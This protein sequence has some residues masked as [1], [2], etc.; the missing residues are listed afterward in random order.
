MADRLGSAK[1]LLK[2]INYIEQSHK[3][4][5]YSVPACKLGLRIWDNGMCIKIDKQEMWVTNEE[6]KIL[7]RFIIDWFKRNEL[8]DNI[9]DKAKEE[10]PIALQ[11]YTPLDRI[12]L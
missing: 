4:Q 12:E 10:V 11:D 1:R 2:K 3:C 6:A 7:S 8:A 5:G 9:I